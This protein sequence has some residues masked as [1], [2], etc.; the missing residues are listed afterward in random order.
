MSRILVVLKREYVASVKTASFVLTTL[1]LPVLFAAVGLLPA[2]IVAVGAGDRSVVVVDGTGRLRGVVEAASAGLAEEA[3][4]RSSARSLG[5]AMGS[6]V[7]PRA[8]RLRLT[9]VAPGD[10]AATSAAVAALLDGARAG[11]ETGGRGVDGVVVLPPAMLEDPGARGAL[12][13]RG[14]DLEAV[15]HAAAVVA[16]GVAVARWTAR[17]RD[18]AEIEGLLSPPA[19][20]PAPLSSSG[21][22]GPGGDLDLLV[23]FGFGGLLFVAI[24]LNGREILRRIVQE[25]SDRIMEI[26]LS[27]VTPFELLS[28]R[29]LGLAAAGL[30]QILVW[31]GMAAVAGVAIGALGGPRLIDAETLLRPMVAVYF[32]VFFLLGY[33]VNVAVYAVGG[34]AAS[35]EKAAQQ[36]MSPISMALS[37]PPFFLVIIAGHPGS[38]LAVVLSMIPIYAPMVM[39]VRVL[40]SD[41]PLW[42]ILVA[43]GGTGATVLLFV[44]VAAKIFRTGVLSHGATPTLRELWRWA[45]A[46]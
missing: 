9:Y 35:S 24:L 2:L 13:A 37:A 16:R 23:A 8:A 42:Q 28:G 33:L 20:D 34:A 10:A 32:V 39:F 3:S 17:G 36:L 26:L 18:A 7:L 22:G 46:R 31:L 40:V 38:T 14:A 15:E 11:V 1:L 44:W 21:P 41:P 19:F 27:S 4:A 30:T 6:A 29:I 12:Y 45:R 43:I 25:K 5:A